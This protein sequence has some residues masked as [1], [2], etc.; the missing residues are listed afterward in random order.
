[1]PCTTPNTLTP[2]T[3]FQSLGVD[4]HTRADGAPTPALLIR[5]LQTPNWRNTWSASESTDPKSETSAWMPVSAPAVDAESS[6]TVLSRAPFSTSESTTLA[7]A[8]ASASPNARPMP[9]APPVT[10]ATMSLKSVMGLLTSVSFPSSQLWVF[11]ALGPHV[12]PGSQE[13]EDIAQE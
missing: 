10:T 8:L 12:G 5:T 13:N 4:S 2:N 7:P 6:S 3:H 1:M 9:E 11:S